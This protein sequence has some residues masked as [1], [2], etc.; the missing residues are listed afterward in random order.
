MSFAE[1]VQALEALYATLPRVD[2]QRQ[3]QEACGPIM[4]SRLEWLRVL[5]SPGRRRTLRDACTCPM[6]LRGACAVYAVRP[7]ICR[8]YGLVARMRCPFGCVPERWV[9]DEEARTLLEAAQAISAQLFPGKAT[10]A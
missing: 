5:R 1:A 10:H 4:M 8:L 7:L 3:C 2:C 9:S 6:L